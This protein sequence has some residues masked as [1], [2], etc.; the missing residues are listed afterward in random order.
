MFENMNIFGLADTLFQGGFNLKTGGVSR[1]NYP[2]VTMPPFSGQVVLRILIEG[3]FT[4]KL[5][6]ITD[7]TS[8]RVLGVFNN[9]ANDIDI[10]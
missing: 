3:G 10:A 7:Q 5:D 6:A 4:G 1:V 9:K 2:T 8:N